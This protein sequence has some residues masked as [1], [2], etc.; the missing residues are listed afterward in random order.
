L[1]LIAPLIPFAV[2]V[3]FMS[4][5]SESSALAA[6]AAYCP[7]S[8]DRHFVQPVPAALR[9]RVA[10][11]FGIRVDQAR[12][13]AAVRC[14]GSQLLV[15]WVGANLNCGKADTRRRLPAAVAF[16]RDNPSVAAVP[17]YATGHD[18]IYEWRCV[19]GRAVVTK[20]MTVDPQGYI[21]NNWRQM[22]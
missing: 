16:C 5:A 15:C 19:D 3:A 21:A 12:D 7:G 20:A 2:L 14:V 6:S 9:E 11:S 4:I 1:S 8:S 10:K 13:A 17:M 22:R 18:T